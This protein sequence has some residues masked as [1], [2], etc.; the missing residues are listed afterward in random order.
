MFDGWLFVVF[1]LVEGWMVC[2]WF[3]VDGLLL[4]I[5]IGWLMM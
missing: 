5:D 4:V 3:V 1:E 2:D